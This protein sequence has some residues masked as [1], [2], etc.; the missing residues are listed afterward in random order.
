MSEPDD[1]ER[2]KEL[3]VNL[4]EK[5][6]TL[7]GHAGELSAKVG[8]V[9]GAVRTFTDAHRFV[10]AAPLDSVVAT[11]F[12]ASGAAIARELDRTLDRLQV[13]VGTFGQLID[14]AIPVF[15]TTSSSAVATC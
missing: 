12:I 14:P 13:G 2:L 3:L 6:D 15:S 11:P 9:A 1:R 8:Y 7:A 5:A 10:L 4:S